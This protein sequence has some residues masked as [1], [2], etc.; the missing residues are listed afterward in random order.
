MSVETCA[1]N[2]MSVSLTILELLE[3]NAPT[4][5]LTGSLHADTQTDAQSDENIISAIHSVYLVKLVKI[6][7]LQMLFSTGAV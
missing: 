4:V 5:W 1:T 2:S 3:F 6:I 7:I